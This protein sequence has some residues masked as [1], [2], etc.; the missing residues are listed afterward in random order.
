MIEKYISQDY[1]EFL[2]GK[3]IELSEWDR[4]TLIFQNSRLPYSEK[5]AD[6]EEIAKQTSDPQLKSQ[7]LHRLGRNNLFF[8][9]FPE[10][11]DDAYFKLSF[12]Y[13]KG[14]E[15][16]GIY[17]N[18]FAAYETGRQQT[19]YDFR[20]EKYNYKD[21]VKLRDCADSSITFRCEDGEV[22][23]FCLYQAWIDNG[24]WNG[25]V[26][27]RFVDLPLVFHQGDIVH[28]MGTEEYGIVSSPVNDTEEEKMLHSGRRSNDFVEFQVVVDLIYRGNKFLSVFA[29]EHL[30]PT[31]LEYARLDDGDTRKGVLEYM[32]KT[33]Y[34]SSWWGSGGRHKGR[35]PEVLKK[36]ETVWR[37]FPDLRFGQ[38]LLSVCAPYNLFTMEDEKLLELLQHN[39][40]PIEE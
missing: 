13:G 7:I 23:D 22:M 36:L 9:K 12:R 15:S 14:F 4:A 40:F 30:P 11:K 29:H 5:E 18:Y 24:R 31:E 16:E 25:D 34:N 39:E 3:G 19:E 33:L 8:E 2:R 6:L 20:I 35:I 27:E 26:E 21:H 32:K 38:L 10:E 28:I 37:Q 17:R 1:M